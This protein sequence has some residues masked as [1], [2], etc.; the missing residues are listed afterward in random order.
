MCPATPCWW[1]EPNNRLTAPEGA[2]GPPPLP[3]EADAVLE[4]MTTPEVPVMDAA[5][6]ASAGGNCGMMGGPGRRADV[7][8]ASDTPCLE[9][10]PAVLFVSDATV[11]LSPPC[12]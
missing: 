7:S 10:P 2:D 12:L 6:L 1:E 4:V 11:A 3:G 8:L 5:T 9:L